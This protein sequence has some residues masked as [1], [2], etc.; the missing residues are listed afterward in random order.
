[1]IY[2]LTSLLVIAATIASVEVS[3]RFWRLLR[4]FDRTDPNTEARVVVFGQLA[5]AGQFEGLGDG[6]VD[7]G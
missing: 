7:A 1:M 5:E 3:Y 4:G 6:G 2:L